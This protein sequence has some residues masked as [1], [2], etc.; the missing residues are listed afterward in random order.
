MKNLI[1]AIIRAVLLASIVLA[2]GCSVELPANPTP[3]PDP[4]ASAGNVTPTP[5]QPLSPVRAEVPTNVVQP[6]PSATTV[7]LGLW[8]DPLLPSA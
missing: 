2:A 8:I 7:K 1:D 3:A 6:L 4:L 5:F